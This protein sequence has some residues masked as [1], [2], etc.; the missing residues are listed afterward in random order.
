MSLL[1]SKINFSLIISTLVK[2]RINLANGLNIKSKLT[3]F[4]WQSLPLCNHT[5]MWSKKYE[6]YS[7]SYLQMSDMLPL[8]STWREH[9]CLVSMH[10]SNNKLSGSI[11]VQFY[12]LPYSACCV[13]LTVSRGCSAFTTMLMFGRKSA[14]YCTH[15]AATAAICI[16]QW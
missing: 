1:F 12:S 6:F 3:L 9:W 4:Y 13:G 5:V 16:T 10:A 2:P 8:P 14:S 15:R 7:G 11:R